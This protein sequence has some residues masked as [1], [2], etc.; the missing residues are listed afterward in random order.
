M[1]TLQPIRIEYSPDHGIKK[2]KYCVK[3]EIKI[4][5]DVIIQ[6]LSWLT[7]AL[8]SDLDYR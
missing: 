8:Q 2:V 6:E 3:K 7:T 5:Q 4:K 1:D